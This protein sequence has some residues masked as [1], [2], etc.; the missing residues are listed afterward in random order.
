[1]NF[2]GCKPQFLTKKLYNGLHGCLYISQLTGNN[3]RP[4]ETIH[5]AKLDICALHCNICGNNNC[6]PRSKTDESQR[7]SGMIFA[8]VNTNVQ[9]QILV[10]TLIRRIQDVCHA[11]FFP[12]YTDTG[13]TELFAF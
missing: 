11:N 4:T 12:G 6:F 9:S 3:Q 2:A 5:K 10:D 8:F 1:M 13:H 7:L